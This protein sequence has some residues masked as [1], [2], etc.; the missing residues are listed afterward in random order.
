MRKTRREL[1]RDIQEVLAKPP[2]PPTQSVSWGPTTIS[3]QP[4]RRATKIEVDGR[5]YTISPARID[6]VYQ[7]YERWIA[8]PARTN[9]D[10]AWLVESPRGD[11]LA[12]IRGTGKYWSIYRPSGRRPW[13]KGDA[14]EIEYYRGMENDWRSVV[15]AIVRLTI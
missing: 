8:R 12:L 11:I 3:D 4:P 9:E 6:T 1:E 13:R 14:A 5:P 15:N 7:Q 10:D 2:P